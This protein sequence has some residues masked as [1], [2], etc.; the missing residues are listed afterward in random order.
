[1]LP[2]GPFG[3][4][5]FAPTLLIRRARDMLAPALG[6]AGAAAFAVGL[7]TFGNVVHALVAYAIGVLADR[8]S[9]RVVLSAGFARSGV[10]SPGFVVADGHETLLALLFA[11]SGVYAAIV[12]WSQPALA[13]MPMR[14]SLR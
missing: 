2:A 3:I 9:R 8:R 10:M 7:Y 5:N 14:E 11:L 4:S 13:S 6:A 12:E 1:M